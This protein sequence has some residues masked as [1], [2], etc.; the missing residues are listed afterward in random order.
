VTFQD[1]PNGPI[2]QLIFDEGKSA[3]IV[4]GVD[5]P[6]PSAPVPVP[7]PGGENKQAVAVPAGGGAGA[8]VR[9]RACQSVRVIG[10]VVS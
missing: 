6:A 5:A 7:V 2:K 10:L 3:E 1:A 8:A 4:P 9:G